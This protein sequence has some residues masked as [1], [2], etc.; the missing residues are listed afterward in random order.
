[1]PLGA[2][3]TRCRWTLLLDATLQLD[4]HHLFDRPNLLPNVIRHLSG[5]RRLAPLFARGVLQ[6]RGTR[7]RASSIE[8]SGRGRRHWIS[9]IL[10]PR[11]GYLAFGSALPSR[12]LG[13]PMALAG[14]CWLTLLSPTLTNY[15][16]P[17]NLASGLLSEGLVMI[18]LLVKGVN[19]QQW[20]EQ[21]STAG[22]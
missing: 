22:A 21:A 3:R 15:R 8:S 9:R 17:Y 2:R 10:L 16:S 11:I 19:D 14:L 6:L 20:K 4:P 13:A 7:L 5:K 1:M 12:I 18:W